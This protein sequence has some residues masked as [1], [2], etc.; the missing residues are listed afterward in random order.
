M[1]KVS[2]RSNTVIFSFQIYLHKDDT[3]MLNYTA[4]RLKIG[5]VH[6]GNKFTSYTVQSQSDLL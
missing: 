5:N 1:I 2:S 3:N 6:V 4:R